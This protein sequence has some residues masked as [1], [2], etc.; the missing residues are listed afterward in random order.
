M[1]RINENSNY[2]KVDYPNKDLITQ[3]MTIRKNLN[4]PNADYPNRQLSE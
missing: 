3:M 1:M 4:Y 2:P